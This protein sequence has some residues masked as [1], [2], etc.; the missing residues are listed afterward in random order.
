MTPAHLS[1]LGTI[2]MVP[3]SCALTQNA[4]EGA[5]VRVFRAHGLPAAH[6]WT[7]PYARL[8]LLAPSVPHGDGPARSVRREQLRGAAAPACG[9]EDGGGGWIAVGAATR[10]AA[11]GRTRRSRS[12]LLWGHG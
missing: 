3:G 6:L 5:Q 1:A 11:Q 9:A 12:P 2:V 8:R 7:S 10:T 4:R